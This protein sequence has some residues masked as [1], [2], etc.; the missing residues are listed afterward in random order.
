MSWSMSPDGSP[1]SRPRTDDLLDAL[2]GVLATPVPG[3][4]VIEPEWL[5]VQSRAM[6]R[7]LTQGLVGAMR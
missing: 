2:A 5:I 1:C 4:D 6:E 7:W 3:R